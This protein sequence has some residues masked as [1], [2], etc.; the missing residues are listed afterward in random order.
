[1][2]LSILIAGRNEQFLNRTIAD[3]LS[4]MRGNSKVVV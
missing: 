2:D 4:N 1:M 3:A